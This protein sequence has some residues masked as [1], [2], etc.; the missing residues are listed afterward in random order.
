[1]YA[2]CGV[3]VERSHS[4]SLAIA[5]IHD[6]EGSNVG[7]YT[8]S[9]RRLGASSWL[10]GC[11]AL[12]L[13]ACA[14]PWWR[15]GRPRALCGEHLRRFASSQA[16]RG[17]DPARK[18]S[19]Q[20]VATRG[21]QAKETNVTAFLQRELTFSTSQIR[22]LACK[23]PMIRGMSIENKLKP[24]LAWL[25]HVV[26]SRKQVAKVVAG[27]PSLLACSIDGNLKP[28]VAWLEDV[29]LSRQ[30][31]AKVVA[32]FPRVL[33]CSIEANLKPTVAW[34]EDIG[35]SRKQRAK[36][37]AVFPQ[38]L[39]YSI[40]G[41]L[42]PTVAG[43]EDVGLSRQQVAKVVAAFPQVLGYSIEANLRLKAAW[44]QDLGVSRPQVAKVIARLPQ[45]CG[46]SIQRNLESK[47]AWLED[48]GLS[49]GQVAKVVS[50]FP[51]VLSLSIKTNLSP[52]HLLLREHFSDGEVRDIFLRRPM[53]LGSSFPRLQ[54]RLH[55]LQNH[56]AV[57]KL[58]SAMTMTS[59]RF[60]ER[61]PS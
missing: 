4:P 44:L 55:V 35:L 3:K 49:R 24:A 36:V 16:D 53:L 26:L 12:G 56:D 52:K 18:F 58:A 9:W 22:A 14:P 2:Y 38:V 17:L 50:S 21:V 45:V 30:Q 28:T 41:N 23:F 37:V 57:T 60:A 6:I 51:Q 27:F 48:V 59:D 42:K 46:Y 34:L 54:H 5:A 43:L 33:G 10:L 39:G 8:M 7:Q 19:T 20:S 1:M 25:E 11:F 32:G 31:V 15:K 47:V 13:A 61:F 29:G 40:D